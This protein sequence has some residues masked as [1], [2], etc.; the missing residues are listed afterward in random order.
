MQTWAR[1][2]LQAA[3]ITGGS[4]MLGTGIA[5]ADEDVNP[6]RP[7]SPLDP[8]VEFPVRVH[9]DAIGAPAGGQEF[10]RAGRDAL[11]GG[12]V[13]TGTLVAKA[14]P[15]ISRFQS[16]VASRVPGFGRTRS[17]SADP[18]DG[19][20]V[21]PHAIGPAEFAGDAGGDTHVNAT[22]A[23]EGVHHSLMWTDDAGDVLG[24]NVVD[25]DWALPMR[26]TAASDIS[27]TAGGNVTTDKVSAIN[28][29]VASV[30]AV[31]AARV[32]GNPVA[33]AGFVD[34]FGA[35]DTLVDDDHGLIAGNLA[36]APTAALA[37]LFGSMPVDMTGGVDSDSESSGNLSDNL[38]IRPVAV[39]PQEFGDAG[40][41]VGNEAGVVRYDTGV[42][43]GDLFA[44]PA[45]A[46]A[47]VF[48]DAAPVGGYADAVAENNTTDPS[49]D[50]DRNS[51]SGVEKVVPL[52][53][54]VQIFD[55]PIPIVAHAIAQGSGNALAK[56]DETATP[57]DSPDSGGSGLAANQLP[58]LPGRGVLLARQTRSDLPA[59]SSSV[60]DVDVAGPSN[61][62][63]SPGAG[64]APHLGRTGVNGVVSP[65]VQ[66]L[67]SGR[68]LA[69][70]VT[71]VLPV[72]SAVD[73]VPVGR[74]RSDLPIAASCVRDVDVAGL[75]DS[76][77]LPGPN[78]APHIAGTGAN[79]AGPAEDVTNRSS[80]SC[81]DITQTLPVVN[82][83]KPLPVQPGLPKL[84]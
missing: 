53:A 8:Q 46:E 58:T 47:Q 40:S 12:A 70:D 38:I 65:E 81:M 75:P 20:K 68:V 16:V 13:T 79:G 23:E 73:V 33:G 36:D 77:A 80:L 69:S 35:N 60:R 32:F 48:G 31:W 17:K 26:I 54:V 78:V 67:T 37:R 21:T 52:G 66:D 4:L 72:V 29:N 24:G 3:L 14:A 15:V 55:I 10:P 30:P 50:G 44:A 22:S 49:D 76:P 6:D 71:E 45:T 34:A 41:L 57:I 11:A 1:R 51:L 2:S 18:F 25:L 61:E 43:S 39:A 62:P 74:S 63:E 82:A 27:S 83:A 5:S 19:N 28:G 7:A 84:A 56:V 64:V 9:D 42:I 59:T